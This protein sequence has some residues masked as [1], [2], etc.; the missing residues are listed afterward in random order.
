MLLPSCRREEPIDQVYARVLKTACAQADMMIAS[1]SPGEYPRSIKDGKLWKSDYRWWCSGYFPGTLWQLYEATGDE[2]Y[3]EPANRLTDGLETLKTTTSQHDIGLQIICSYGRRF[4]L[5]GDDADK[6]EIIASA[7]HLA[8]RF[9]PNTKCTLSWDAPKDRPGVF[10]VIID[11]MMVIEL[12][13]EATRLSG[14]TSF[15]DIAVTHSLTTIKNHF[16]PDSSSWHV[17]E[18]D[19]E[20]GEVTL[21][22]T[23][24]GYSDDSAWARG[25]AWGLYGYT[26]MYRYTKDAR[27]L[28]Q[29]RKIAGYILSRLPEDWIPYWDYDDPAIPNAPR[30]ASS[31]AIQA[32]ALVELSGF[33]SGEERELYLNVAEKTL[34]ALSSPEYLAEPGTNCGFI[35]K[36]S[37][38]HLKA[39]SEVDVPLTYADYYFLE[40][41]GRYMKRI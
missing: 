16:R 19:P 10:Q 25:Q 20:T 2:K 9:N 31:A 14:D 17:V 13:M 36:H 15:S 4:N 38:G 12:L 7:K 8:G 28:E 23:H 40:A 22:R 41:F 6:E 33:V 34:R 18:Y 3:I 37:T 1:L 39:N 5:F 11:N 30:D 21:K 35:L 26:M 27:F 24:Q 29:A 32:S